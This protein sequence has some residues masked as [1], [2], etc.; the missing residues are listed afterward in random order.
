VEE[1]IADHEL[2]QVLDQMSD[3]VL[4]S[5]IGDVDTQGI[6]RRR[7]VHFLSP[8]ARARAAASS[9]AMFKINDMRSRCSTWLTMGGMAYRTNRP[10]ACKNCLCRPISQLT[11]LES[12]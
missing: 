5:A 6:G 10:P 2:R 8:W 9:G 4:G 3:R 11:P 1:Q 12:M 7:R